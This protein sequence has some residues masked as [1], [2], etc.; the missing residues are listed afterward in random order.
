MQDEM[1]LDLREVVAIIRTRMKLIVV[2]TFVLTI[3]SGIL[4]F[5]VIKPTYEARTS[6]VIGKDVQKSSDGYSSSDVVMYQ[7]LIKTYA[8]IAKTSDVAIDAIKSMRSNLSD[9]EVKKEAAELQ[10]ASKIT[11][12]VDTQILDIKIQSK[13]PEEAKKMVDA[14]T[15][16][17]MKAAK[18]IYPKGHIEIMDT[19]KVPSKPIK[20]NKKLNIAIAFVL[21]L[22]LSIGIVF[23]L[24]YMDNTIKTE[25]D[26]EK[27]LKVPVI[28]NIPHYQSL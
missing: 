2:I 28:G 11:P 17:F 10:K 5:Y 12:Q 22:I 18:K 14:L 13:N 16:S 1:T 19:A 8:E 25:E 3:I 4:S 9:E 20:P 6:I 7:K 15:I 26:V 27:L 21:G 23:L 24:E